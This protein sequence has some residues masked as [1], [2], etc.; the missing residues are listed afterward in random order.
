MTPLNEAEMAFVTMWLFEFGNRIVST[1]EWKNTYLRHTY[2][3]DNAI[4][5]HMMFAGVDGHSIN[6]AVIQQYFNQ[7]KEKENE[8]Q[9]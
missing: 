8:H 6:K 5:Y 2:L 9:K 3:E 7:V 4:R 1:K